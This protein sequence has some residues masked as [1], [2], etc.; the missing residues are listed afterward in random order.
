MQKKNHQINGLLL[1]GGQKPGRTAYMI[2]RAYDIREEFKEGSEL[3]IELVQTN[4]ES[5]PAPFEI[6]KRTLLRT[7]END[8]RIPMN[9][10]PITIPVNPEKLSC[11][12]NWDKYFGSFA[13]WRVDMI[14]PCFS[15]LPVELNSQTEK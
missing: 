1:H 12:P 7:D 8:V 13:F 15:C 10:I 14:E 3:N 9:K 2:S 5:L 6:L 11:K 4:L